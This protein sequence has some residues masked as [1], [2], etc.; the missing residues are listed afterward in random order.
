M[1]VEISVNLRKKIDEIKKKFPTGK[2]PILPLLHAFQD[3]FGYI[4]VEIEE[5]IAKIVG[6]SPVYVR[7]VSTFYSMFNNKPVGKYHIQ[8]C[9]NISCWLRGYDEIVEYI[10]KKLGIEIGETTPDGKFTLSRVECLGMCDQAPVMQING[11]FY[12]NLTPEKIDEILD[13]LE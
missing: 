1:S 11:D 2:S 4:S 7:E 9:G 3:E 13:N 10:K 12:G 6:V 5:E 8:V